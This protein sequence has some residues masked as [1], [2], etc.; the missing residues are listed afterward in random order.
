MYIHSDIEMYRNGFIR[1]IYGLGRMDTGAYV[2]KRW[3]CI[4]KLATR[5]RAS[6]TIIIMSG[7]CA[8]IAKQFSAEN[9]EKPVT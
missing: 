5:A 6:G 7:R 9:G 2:A 3:H 4:E 8:T 1:S